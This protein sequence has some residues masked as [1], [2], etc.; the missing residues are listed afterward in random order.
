MEGPLTWPSASQPTPSGSPYYSRLN[1]KI[2]RSDCIGPVLEDRVR[3]V[4]N[5]SG[6][7]TDSS[8]T[9]AEQCWIASNVI[10]RL[11]DNT[12]ICF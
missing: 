10:Q 8:G 4:G 5:S 9:H 7:E 3:R 12:F 6:D 2:W 1:G 11:S